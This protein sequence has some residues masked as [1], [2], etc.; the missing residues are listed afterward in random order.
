MR[1]PTAYQAVYHFCDDTLYA[2]FMADIPSAYLREQLRSNDSLRNRYF[3][4]FRITANLPSDEQIL[5][6]IHREVVERHNDRIASPLCAMWVR[7]HRQLASASLKAM[8]IDAQDPSDARSWIGEVQAKLENESW[9]ESIRALVSAVVSQF[10]QEDVLIFVSLISYGLDQIAVR[11][12][13]EQEILKTAD[14]PQQQKLFLEGEISSVALAIERLELQKNDFLAAESSDMEAQQKILDQLMQE[15]H[16][17]DEELNE[18][19]LAAKGLVD[20][21]EKLRAALD[22]KHKERVVLAKKQRISKK[23]IQDQQSAIKTLKASTESHLRELSQE[24]KRDS[25]RKT[26]LETRLIDAAK[27][28]EEAKNTHQIIVDIAAGAETTTFC[29]AGVF[30][31]DVSPTTIGSALSKLSPKIIGNNAICY[32]GIQRVFRNSVVS[33]LRERFPRLFP[34][35]HNLRLK[36]LFGDDWTKAAENANLSRENLGTTTAIRDDYDLLGINH[37]Y[38]VFDQYYDR[39]FSTDAGQPKNRPRPVKARFLGNVK[40]IKD[41]RDPLSHP[42]DEEL[43]FEEA[44]HLL[45]SAQEVLKWL[46]C[47]T[48]AEELADLLSRLGGSEQEDVTMLRRLPSED[49]IYL[50][51][52]GRGSLL[53]ELRVCFSNPDNRRCLLAGDGGKGKSAAA[54]RFAQALPSAG[55]RFQ[56]MIWLSAKQRRFH[57]GTTTSVESPD[58]SSAADAVDRLLI[59]YGATSEDMSKPPR[60]KKQLL[61][62]YLQEFPAFII[63]DD[64]DSV[65]EDEEVVSLFTHEIPHT[66]SAVLLTS[67]RSIPGIRTFSVSGFD[68]NEAEEFVKSRI[69]LYGLNSGTFTS[70]AIKTITKITDGS[71]LYMDDL[72]RLAKIVD[73][74][75]AINTWSDKGGRSTKIC[76]SARDRE[77]INRL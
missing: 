20:E 61:F 33:F 72:L 30:D 8:G 74:Q 37:F 66:Q 36:K 54:F 64:I 29:E 7:G 10:Q 4:G 24:I 39:L 45:Y 9:T 65:L 69:R 38:S 6:A 31:N 53:N 14:D 44:H 70:S 47:K 49:S 34:N 26:E 11:Q 62:E 50:D 46:G 18:N 19:E 68:A 1:D 67:R 40:A 21:L 32:Q 58:F 28:I 25:K 52:V 15:G 55:G 42:V 59:E 13:V 17:S 60:E 22:E 71:P 75:T 51:F 41:G 77:I 57:Q 76:P 63:A 27:A 3:P 43:S 73:L 48:E 23:A 35:D 16:R 56:L 12:V 5:H 2:A